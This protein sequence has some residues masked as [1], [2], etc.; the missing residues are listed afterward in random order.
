MID[1]LWK[2]KINSEVNVSEIVVSA[3]DSNCLHSSGMDFKRSCLQLLSPI[4][5][6]NCTN[7]GK[8]HLYIYVYVYYRHNK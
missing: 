3:A 7:A 2:A 8:S 4:G 6:S 1:G 5:A